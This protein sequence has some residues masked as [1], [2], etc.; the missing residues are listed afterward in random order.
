MCECN[1][2]AED[3]SEIPTLTDPEKNAKWENEI[4]HLLAL[5]GKNY[6]FTSAE[7]AAFN[8]YY[9]LFTPFRWPT[10]CLFIKG[11]KERDKYENSEEIPE[12]I[13]DWIEFRMAQ[14]GMERLLPKDTE[15]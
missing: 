6:K 10:F 9:T 11:L 4:S 8:E 14:K 2:F 3:P 5:I 13:L 15:S 7:R 1:S 12:K